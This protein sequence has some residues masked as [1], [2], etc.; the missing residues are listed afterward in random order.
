MLR[1]TSADRGATTIEWEEETD[2]RKETVVNDA[3]ENEH[4]LPSPSFLN[5]EEVEYLMEHLNRIKFLF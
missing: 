3:V 1:H 4:L 5:F 2:T